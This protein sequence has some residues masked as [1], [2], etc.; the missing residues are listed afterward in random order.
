MGSSFNRN[1][2]SETA[3]LRSN[4]YCFL[5]QV[6]L[7]SP[8][9]AGFD[10]LLNNDII[11]SLPEMFGAT[12]TVRRLISYIERLRSNT[13]HK[14]KVILDYRNLFAAPGSGKQNDDCTFGRVWG[15]ATASPK[16]RLGTDCTRASLEIHEH[17]GVELQFL[18]FL[19]RSEGNVWKSGPENRAFKLRRWQAGFINEHFGP[20]LA[21]ACSKMNG[22]ARTDFYR[23]IAAITQDFVERDFSL[24]QSLTLQDKEERVV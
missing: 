18:G 5:A 22:L 16:A 6:F 21:E 11:G 1:E 17:I 10:R 4:V 23:G 15:D 3:M 13:N 12:L 8:E 20:W 19:C 9:E 2:L 24:L 7:R 14:N